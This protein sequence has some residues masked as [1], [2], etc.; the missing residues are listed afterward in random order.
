MPIVNMKED[1]HPIVPKKTMGG[2]LDLEKRMYDS[3]GIRGFLNLL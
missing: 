3:T 2:H 1:P